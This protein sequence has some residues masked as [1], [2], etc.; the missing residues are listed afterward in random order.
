MRPGFGSYGCW[1]AAGTHHV[2]MLAHEVRE[3]LRLAQAGRSAEEIRQCTGHLRNHV[4]DV[5]RH[6]DLASS[7]IADRGGGP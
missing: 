3:V 1:P 7:F 5:R 4:A 2:A 6:P